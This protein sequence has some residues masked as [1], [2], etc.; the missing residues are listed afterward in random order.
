M[1]GAGTAEGSSTSSAPGSAMLML[2][3]ADGTPRA[4]SGGGARPA[5]AS[6]VRLG[7]AAPASGGGAGAADA[8]AVGAGA[9]VAGAAGCGAADAGVV[10]A[11][12]VG[13]AGAAVVGAVGAGAGR[14]A[15]A[16]ACTAPLASRMCTTAPARSNPA[17]YLRAVASSRSRLITAR[18]PENS[19]STLATSVLNIFAIAAFTRSGS[20]PST[21][22]PSKTTWKVESVITVAVTDSIGGAALVPQAA[23]APRVPAAEPLLAGRPWRR[24]GSTRWPSPSPRAS[25][26][27]RL[28]VRPRT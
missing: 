12:A 19:G 2:S 27:R 15:G 8:G 22:C 18:R 11:G 7:P 1:A 26:V 9:A 21:S 4:T 16:A 20:A 23:A 3:G 24:A 14:A 10:G 17:R 25:G 13:A 28:G 6:A 5:S